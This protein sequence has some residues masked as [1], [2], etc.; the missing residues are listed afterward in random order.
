MSGRK[1]RIPLLDDRRRFGRVLT[2]TGVVGILSVLT[3][4]VAGWILAERANTRLTATVEPVA[5]LVVDLS[6]SVE[7]G[8]VI[9]ARTIG[10][11]ESIESATVSSGETLDSVSQVIGNTSD[12]V[13][14]DLADGLETAVD[15][16]PALVDTGR[17]VDRTMRALSLI[18]VD[19]D[20]A[21]P[22]D[23]SLTEL[24]QSLRP[25]PDQLRGQVEA[26]DAIQTD[27]D[28]IIV[29][30]EDLATT[31]EL[32]RTK[33]IEAQTV[34]QSTSGN[35]DEA[36]ASITAM[37]E[38]LDTYDLLTKTVVVAVAVAL[39]A[40]ASVPLLMGLRYQRSGRP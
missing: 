20:P 7:A 29:D 22:L 19:Y 16:L 9:V 5:A 6:D 8:Q 14:G 30:A 33:M 38:E 37:Q 23:Q 31:L 11:I 27:I 28:L 13:G 21:A 40:A 12:V 34:L 39:L 4:A 2:T 25:I 18:G 1:K 3:F 10:A 36:G 15:T 35:V 24:E 26:L 17:V 32:A